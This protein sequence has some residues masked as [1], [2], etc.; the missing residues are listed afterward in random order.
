MNKQKPSSLEYEGGTAS[1]NHAP[2]GDTGDERGT[3]N[4]IHNLDLQERGES[5][6]DHQRDRNSKGVA[7]GYDDSVEGRKGGGDR[8]YLGVTRGD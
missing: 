7:D 2:M 4:R 1:G 5:I 3:G 6:E 8:D